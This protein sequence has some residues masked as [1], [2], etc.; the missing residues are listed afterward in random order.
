MV[1]LY[2]LLQEIQEINFVKPAQVQVARTDFVA[3]SVRMLQMR[4]Q[5]CQPC[6]TQST[7]QKAR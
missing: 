1:Q 2:G 4:F 7:S 6:R 5:I 3:G